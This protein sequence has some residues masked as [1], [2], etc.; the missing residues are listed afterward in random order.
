MVGFQTV[1]FVQSGLEIRTR[2]TET[3]FQYGSNTERFIVLISS[4]YGD[5]QFGDHL[6]WF[7]KTILYKNKKLWLS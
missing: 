4:Y 6:V 2:K 5:G 3:P 7:L 1:S